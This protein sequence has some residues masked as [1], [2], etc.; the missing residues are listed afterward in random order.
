MRTIHRR[1]KAPQLAG[2][3]VRFTVVGDTSRKRGFAIEIKPC[4]DAQ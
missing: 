3:T 4:S 1:H 2:A